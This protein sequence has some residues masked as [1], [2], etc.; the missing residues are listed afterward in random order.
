MW[1]KLRN[2][3]PHSLYLLHECILTFNA[4]TAFK[5]FTAFTVFA[6]FTPFTTFTNCFHSIHQIQ[7][8]YC[9]HFTHSIHYMKS[10]IEL[11]LDAKQI[12]INGTDQQPRQHAN[13][14]TDKNTDRPIKIIKV[15]KSLALHYNQREE[16]NSV[17]KNQVAFKRN[18]LLNKP[19][20]QAAGK[21]PSQCNSTPSVKWLKLLNNWWN[22][23]ALWNLESSWSLWLG[24]FYNWKT[25][26]K[27]YGG[28]R[29]VKLLETKGSVTESVI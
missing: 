15:S 19:A 6:A 7:C 29:A 18:K 8:F 11:W 16:K 4:F 14:E 5:A 23:Y 22:F 20:A 9:I 2:T 21:D 27:P 17:K 24:Q 1:V 3:Y 25:Y 13:Q 26:F 10:V 12:T 28:S